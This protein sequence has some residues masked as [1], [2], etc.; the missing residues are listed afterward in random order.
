[1]ATQAQYVSTPQVWAVS[2]STANTG[3]DGTGA[4]P[5]LVTGAATPGTRIDR[6]RFIAVG[7]TT[8]GMVRVFLNDGTTKRMIRELTV[9]A[10]TPSGTV[11]GW[12][13]EWTF[14]DGLV[15]PSA[16]WSILVST[17]NAEAFNVF[18]FGGNL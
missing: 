8:A 10:I 12:E 14:G 6:I 3:K 17:H 2:L 13:K 15:L 7:T 5:T 18:A 9:D 1:M 16:S 4:A 11:P